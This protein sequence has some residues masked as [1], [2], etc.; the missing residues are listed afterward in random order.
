MKNIL[1]FFDLLEDKIR[2]RLSHWPILYALVGIVGIV[3]AWRGVWHIA[4]DWHMG[5]WL[6]LILGVLILLS[7]GLLIAIAIGDEVIINSFR[8]RRKITEVRIEETLTMAEKVDEIKNL[9]DKMEKRLSNIK[10]EE[11]EIEREIEKHI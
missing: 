7:S 11:Q 4:D 5:G 8:G 6:S 1:R 2:H 9:L 3:L 10:K